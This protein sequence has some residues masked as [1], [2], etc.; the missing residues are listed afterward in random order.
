MQRRRWLAG[1][2]W[3]CCTEPALLWSLCACF[4]ASRLVP[5]PPPPHPGPAD[6]LPGGA[7]PRLVY[8]DS[9]GDWLLLQPE[10]PWQLFQRT[11]RKLVISCRQ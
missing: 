10:A 6:K 8:Q 1:A 2:A 5:P 11:V 3:R 7:Q 9:D 4:L